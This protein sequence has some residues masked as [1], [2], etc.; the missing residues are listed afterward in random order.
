M[1]VGFIILR[2][3]SS[4]LTNRYWINCY[5]SIRKLYP[6]NHVLIIDDNSDY[7]YISDEPLYKTTI[8]NSEYPKRGELLPYI[9]YLNNK[10]FD[11]AVILHDSVYINRYTTF[12]IENYL[13]F[14]HFSHD[15]D[16]IED[17]TKMIKIFNDPELL[18]FYEDKSKWKGCFGVMTAIKHDFLTEINKKY[19]LNKLIEQVTSRNKRCCLERVFAC[20]LQKEA[21]MVSLFGNITEYCPWGIT[22]EHIDILSFLPI[23]KVW[24]AR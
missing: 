14:W 4:E 24:T 16:Q 15:W 6:E 21:P 22:Y 23:V 10:L 2:H 13:V 1:S 17:E 8:I 3:V 9:Y 12:T 20:L 19:D 7:K 5:N 11:T 18:K